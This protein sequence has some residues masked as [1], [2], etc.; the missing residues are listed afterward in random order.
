LCAISTFAT[1]RL[2]LADIFQKD[3][4][5]SWQITGSPRGVQQKL[6]RHSN[7]ATTMNVHGNAMPEG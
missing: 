2:L 6:M 5:T 4:K 3:G 1:P 7:V